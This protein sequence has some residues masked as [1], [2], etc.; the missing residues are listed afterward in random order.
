MAEALAVT[1]GAQQAPSSSPRSAG[2]CSPAPGSS[3][4]DLA[5]MLADERIT[6]V[7]RGFRIR[8]TPDY[9]VEVHKMLFNWRVVVFDPEDP[10][11]IDRGFCYVGTG[12]ETLAR[13][14]AAGLAWDDPY[15]TDP[16]GADK[17]AFGAQRR[18]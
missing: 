2:S 14:V 13:A 6:R 17:H 5:T 1:P 8:A 4:P 11:A 9:V 10:V 7:E 15:G 12:L 16:T 18:R 3:G